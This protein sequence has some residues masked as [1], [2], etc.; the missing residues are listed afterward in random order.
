MKCTSWFSRPRSS[1]LTLLAFS[2]ILAVA[3][4]GAADVPQPQVIEK[5]VITEVQVTKE[6]VTEVRQEQTKV[7]V[8]EVVATA[9][10]IPVLMGQTFMS[11]LTPDWVAQGKYQPMVLG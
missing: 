2:L 10:P 3:C 5:E 7:V 11:P 9:T 1:I 8:K 6:V 4:G